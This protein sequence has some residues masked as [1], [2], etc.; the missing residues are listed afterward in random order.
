MRRPG[1]PT[2]AVALGLVLTAGAGTTT[3]LRGFPA[4]PARTAVVADASSAVSPLPA[5][6]LAA[7]LPVAP[8]PAA[9]AA[10]VSPPSSS[11]PS[12]APAVRPLGVLHDP[13]LLVEVPGG[14]TAAQLRALDDV[15]G[16]EALTALDLGTVRVA[17]GTGRVAGVDPSAFRAFTPKE[18][19][20][21]DPLWR[22][23]ARGEIASSYG[24]LRAR[25]LDLGARVALAADARV[26]ERIGAVASFAVPDVDLVVSRDVARRLGVVRSSAVL[27]TAPRRSVPRLRRAV[28]QVT[29][30]DARVTVL[31][32]AAVAPQRDRPRSYRELYVQ[33][34]RYCPGLSWTVLA[35][36]GQIESGHGR[37]NG[38]SSAGALGP[39]QF[40]PATWASYGVDGD[41]DGDADTMDPFDAVPAAALYLCRHGAARGEQGLYDAVFAYNHADWYV[42]EVLALAEAYRAQG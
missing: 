29:G 28:L 19:A 9:P 35:A 13:D 26:E 15:T 3:A 18:T 21:S 8:A 10:P 16:V 22:A 14:L 37:N 31:R 34:A 39:M 6:D 38:P 1:L 30:T 17:G 7:P 2:A 4:E 12:S 24:L 33:S 36:I 32:Q 41:G 25:D 27:L 40:M 5:L 20:A 23:V 11:S 42:R